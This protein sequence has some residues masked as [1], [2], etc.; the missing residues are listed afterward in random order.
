MDS[1]ENHKFSAFKPLLALDIFY[2]PVESGL[3]LT[4]RLF[5]GNFKKKCHTGTIAAFI[6][7]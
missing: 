7:Y 5:F 3:I 1:I 4:P 2:K 6:F